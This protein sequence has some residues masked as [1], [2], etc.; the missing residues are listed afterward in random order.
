MNRQEAEKR[1]RE[2]HAVIRHHDYQYYVK[3]TP[4]VADS[5]Y[6]RLFAELKQLEA[7]FPELAVPDSPT[8]RVGGVRTGPVCQGGT[9]RPN[10]EPRF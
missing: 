6:D 5:E 7:L 1:V 2:L 9:R 10:V 3:D 8:Q 4:D